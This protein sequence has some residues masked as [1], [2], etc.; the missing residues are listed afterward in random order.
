[1]DMKDYINENYADIALLD[2]RIFR[3]ENCA[4]AA[5]QKVDETR[6]RKIEECNNPGER[7]LSLGAGLLGQFLLH[8][9]GIESAA[10]QFEPDGR[11][12]VAGNAAF[13]SLSHSGFFAMAGLS[14]AP[15][16]V[17]VELHQPGQMFIAE[18]FF[19]PDELQ[20][21]AGDADKLACFYRIWSRKECII[22]RDGLRD[23][24]ELSIFEAENRGRFHD[25][26]LDGYSCVCY[27]SG[28]IQPQLYILSREDLSI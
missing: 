25:F 3:E 23:L 27:V 15:I 24:R 10:L 5:L 18:H 12:V 2:C 6:R 20:L 22:K 26:P 1:M 21:M 13:L 8:R 11:P 7:W 9:R 4:R 19:T 17:D 16:G 28:D 14:S